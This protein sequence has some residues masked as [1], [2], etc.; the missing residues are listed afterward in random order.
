L[1][2]SI[3]ETA[4]LSIKIALTPLKPENSGSV[5]EDGSRLESGLSPNIAIVDNFTEGEQIGCTCE[6]VLARRWV[7]GNAIKPRS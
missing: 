5:D 4:Y 7:Y 1:R 3:T 6:A 2:V